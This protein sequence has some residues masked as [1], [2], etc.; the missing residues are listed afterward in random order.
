MPSPAGG[1]LVL[2]PLI[3]DVSGLDTLTLNYQ[4]ITPIIFI[5]TSILL[6]SKIPT[7]SLKKIIVPRSST[8]FLLFG[9]ILLFGLLLIF[10][11]KALVIGCLIY[12]LAIPA[13]IIH[14]KKLKKLF[15]NDNKY[16]EEEPEDVL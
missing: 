2:S 4:F 3:F 8:V 6:I 11:F 10:T 5:L 16:D 1:I 15:A 14:Y 13:S 12:I 9:I 7:Y